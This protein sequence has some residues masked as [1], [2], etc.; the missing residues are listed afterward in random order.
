L[1]TNNWSEWKNAILMNQKQ[2]SDDVNILQNS[3]NKLITEVALLKYKST[4]WGA[5]GA[6]LVLLFSLIARG[7]FK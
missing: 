3:V 4:L 2:M 1:E 6:G 7:I 5:V